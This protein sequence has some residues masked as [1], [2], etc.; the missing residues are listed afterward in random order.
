MWNTLAQ[1][2]QK[3]VYAKGGNDYELHGG[4]VRPRGAR[5][6]DIGLYDVRK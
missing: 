6:W 1:V 3:I 5:K 4:V 2:M